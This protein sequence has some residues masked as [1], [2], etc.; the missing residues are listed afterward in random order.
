MMIL[1]EKRR[2]GPGAVRNVRD[3]DP[4][5]LQQ[6]HAALCQPAQRLSVDLVFDRQQPGRQG[7]GRVAGQHRNGALGDDRPV[8]E[9]RGDEMHGAA[10]P[11]HALGQGL[12]MGMQ[13]GEGRQQ[14]RMDVDDAAVEMAH[15]I[16]A[17]HPHEAGQQDVVGRQGVQPC[18]QGGVEGFAAVE[19]A[20]GQGFGGQAARA[21][22][23]QPRRVGAVGQH[24][25]YI[26][27]Q[28]FGR[29][30]LGQR[31]HVRAAARNQDGHPDRPVGGMRHA[32]GL[33]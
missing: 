7:V 30:G 19:V 28:A 31:L 17:Q 9:H 2:A 13:T 33:Q 4:A 32:R 23:V 12:G 1:V 27:G 11:L 24:G 22:P 6:P 25:T 8:V 26:D 15:E 18:P 20:V 14:R 5:V 10:M 16:G 29:G 3:R 21:R